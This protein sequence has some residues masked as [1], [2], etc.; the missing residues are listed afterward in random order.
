VRDYLSQQ[1]GTMRDTSKAHP[2]AAH[3]REHRARLID[4]AAAAADRDG[5]AIDLYDVRST[6]S[7][8]IGSGHLAD[9][10]S[11]WGAV[12]AG[13]VIDDTV[14]DVRRVT[15]GHELTDYRPA[16]YPLVSVSKLDELPFDDPTIQM[17]N[18]TGT[19]GEPVRLRSRTFKLAF[20]RELVENDDRAAMAATFKAFGAM[21]GRR[22]GRD[23]GALLEANG[24]LADGV[25]LF[26]SAEGNDL[27]SAGV[28]LAAVGA[29]TAALRD[30]TTP[31]SEHYN[32]RPA[33]LIVPSAYEA[34]ARTVV[35]AMYADD[36]PERLRVIASPWL[37]GSYYYLAA[38]P[39]AAP[40]VAL[41]TMA[42]GDGALMSAMP[43]ARSQAAAANIPG[44][45]R[46]ESF[47]GVAVDARVT[48]ALAPVARNIIRN[49][50]A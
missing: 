7:A 20:S 24:T 17:V 19:G 44:T 28:D 2:L 43:S 36:D 45:S 31:D 50:T 37:G 35:A 18:I 3:F 12:E 42:G 10:L 48:F 49:T 34:T 6:T 46:R 11:T 33:A 16:N 39:L 26:A 13:A 38:D 22:L 30:R 40:S 14:A 9:V 41:L 27:T 23:Y 1:S 47:D 5:T 25:A 21:V 32:A 29:M 4:L 8:V 15:T